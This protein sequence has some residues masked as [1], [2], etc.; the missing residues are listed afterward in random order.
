ME[1]DNKPPEGFL[2]YQNINKLWTPLEIATLAA[3]VIIKKYGNK[4]KKYF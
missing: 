3:A 4:Q 1:L 2:K